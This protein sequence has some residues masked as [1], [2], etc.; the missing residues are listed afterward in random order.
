MFVAYVVHQDD[1]NGAQ[2]LNAMDTLSYSRPPI[3]GVVFNGIEGGLGSYG[4]GYGYGKYGYG[5]YGYGKYG[6][7]GYGY[8]E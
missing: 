1:A 5:K 2:I 6:K 4:T 7:S 8:G 3:V